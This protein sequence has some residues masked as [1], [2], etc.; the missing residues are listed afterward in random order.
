LFFFEKKILAF[1]NDEENKNVYDELRLTVSITKNL[2]LRKKMPSTS[3]VQN[4]IPAIVSKITQ[5]YPEEIKHYA[6]LCC[7]L[8]CK[9]PGD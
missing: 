9:D 2:K 8:L 5:E 3:F 1:I 7:I 4:F 6:V